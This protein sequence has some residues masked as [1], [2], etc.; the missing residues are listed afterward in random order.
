MTE[1]LENENVQRKPTSVQ[2]LKRDM[3]LEGVVKSLA[4]FGVFVDIGVERDG[5]VHISQLGR[6]RLN[7]IS[8][9]EKVTVWIKE[10]DPKRGRTSLT[11]RRPIKRRLRD[12]EPGMVIKGTVTDLA[13]F[14][15]FV[16]IGAIRDG[17]VHI[18]E[19]APGYVKKP[20]DVVS[21]GDEVEVRVVGVDPKKR[22]IEL[23]ML[24]LP[25]DN[26]EPDEEKLPTAVAL[27]FR[28]A[29]ARRK[30]NS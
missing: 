17:L 10:V 23:S 15:A 12:L 18:S 20:E 2:E 9:G 26:D 8:E 28:E 27:A 14:G 7:D 16:D 5:L 1:N 3:K 4:P 19:L 6:K 30:G 13:P 25:L 29:M 11:M 24:D 21:V 22:K